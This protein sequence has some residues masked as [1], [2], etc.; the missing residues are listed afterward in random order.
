MKTQRGFT[1]IELLVVIAIIGILAGMVVV[2]MSS[3]PD[4]AKNSKLQSYFDQLRT[5]AIVFQTSQSSPTYLNFDASG[6]GL[7]LKNKIVEISNT[8][9]ASSSA[10]AFCAKAKYTGT[11]STSSTYWCI[12]S[13]N[14]YSGTSTAAACTTTNWDCL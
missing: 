1:L 11:G 7:I 12:D 3:A 10:A 13:D 9:N 4:A 14:G 8:Y 6:D 5:A 2:N